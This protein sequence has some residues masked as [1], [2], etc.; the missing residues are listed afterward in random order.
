V[1][2]ERIGII[3]APFALASVPPAPKAVQALCACLCAC[4]FKCPGRANP[5]SSGVV[6][7]FGIKR[8]VRVVMKLLLYSVR[9]L[10]S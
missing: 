4:E 10:S 2:V 9:L 1:P 8:R 7:V 5:R 6:D 3:D